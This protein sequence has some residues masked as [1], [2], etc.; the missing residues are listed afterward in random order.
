MFMPPKKVGTKLDLHLIFANDKN[1]L[2]IIVFENIWVCTNLTFVIIYQSIL[3]Y[4]ITGAQ[5]K[6]FEKKSSIGV[7]KL[8]MIISQSIEEICKQIAGKG[9]T[10][11]EMT[12]GHTS[13]ETIVPI[14]S[15]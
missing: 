5:L 14:H 11:I 3:Y 7:A 10:S 4:F 1:T 6:D 8:N 15:N 12:Q 9:N 13:M 2:I